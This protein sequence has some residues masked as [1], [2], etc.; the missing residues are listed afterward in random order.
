MIEV[1]NTVNDRLFKL[2]STCD[3]NET[4]QLWL[5]NLHPT[6]YTFHPTSYTLHQDGDDRG[7]QCSERQII[8]I[9]QYAWYEWDSW[10]LTPNPKTYTLHP[11]QGGRR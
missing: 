3:M 9:A 11:K 1:D 5:Y 8:Q 2:H 4:G 10:T 6:P 7:A